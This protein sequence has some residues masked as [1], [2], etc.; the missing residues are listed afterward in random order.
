[1][2]KAPVEETILYVEALKLHMSEVWPDNTATYSAQGAQK[3]DKIIRTSGGSPSA[4]AFV[5]RATGDLIKA[6]GWTAPAKSKKHPS[7]LAARYNLRDVEDRARAVSD[8]DP[9]GR[10]LYAS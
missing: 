1:M 2:A 5:N 10:F 7:G 6:A 3:F 4:Y 8:A 9:Y